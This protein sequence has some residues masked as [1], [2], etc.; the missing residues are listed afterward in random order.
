MGAWGVGI[1]QDD[2]VCDVEGAFK[3]HLKDGKSIPDA[4]QAVQEQFCEA[5]D[6]CDEGPLFWIAI[7]DMQWTYGELDPVVLERVKGIVDTHE[8]MERWSEPS[9]PE[10]RKRRVALAKFLDKLS[11]P[12]SKPSRRPRRVRRRPRFCEGDCL[13]IELENGQHGAGI[14]LATD[15]SDP[16]YGLDLVGE[17]TYLS[18]HPP[19]IEVFRKR[20]WLRPTHHNWKGKL[21]LSW[22]PPIGFRA[23]KDRLAVVG[24]IPLLPSDPRE[25]RTC[26]GWHLIGRQV[27]LQH[28]WDSKASQ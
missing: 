24:N 9:E 14:V 7:S 22:Y 5:L 19:T 3:D 26:S 28:E 1:R 2:F 4:T 17:L 11:H 25:S 18:D 20:D 13:S 16:E 8:G 23:M 10:Y 27:L 12:N 15:D 6:D 21:Q